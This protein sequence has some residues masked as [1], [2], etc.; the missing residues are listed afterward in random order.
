MGQ[1][2]E[3][4]RPTGNAKGVPKR[5]GIGL[6]SA[7]VTI[8]RPASSGKKQTVPHDGFLALEVQMLCRFSRV[9]PLMLAGALLAGACTDS[10]PVGPEESHFTRPTVSA[11]GFTL[12][13][14]DAP[15]DVDAAVVTIS[16]VNLIGEGSN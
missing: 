10:D 11:K 15:G 1:K 12:L 6:Q 14:T 5:P 9:S 4:V 16:E 7:D 3:P 13:L 2:L 8:R